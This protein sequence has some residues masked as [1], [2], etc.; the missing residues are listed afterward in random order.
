M[1]SAIIALAVLIIADAPA[2]AETPACASGTACTNQHPSGKK[3]A[4][5]TNSGTG[6]DIT[7]EDKR[8]LDRAMSRNIMQSIDDQLRRQRGQ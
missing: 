3:A 5:K 1:K 7:A 8:S 4:Q 6:R 2:C